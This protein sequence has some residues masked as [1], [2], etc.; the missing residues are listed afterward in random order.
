VNGDGNSRTKLSKDRFD[1]VIFDMDGVITK[2]ATLHATA[3]KELFDAVLET[4]LRPG[5]P[6]R[7]FDIE[8]DYR[9]YVDGKPR[10]DGVIS[11]LASR[12]IGLP[13]GNPS[14]PPTTLTVCGLGNRKNVYFWRLVEK[15]GVEAFA[16]TVDLIHDLKAV[17]IKVGVFSASGNAESILN[18][19]QV[20]AL[21][22]AKVDGTDAEHLELPGKPHPAML[23]EL[24]RRLGS[25]PSRTA[26]VEDAIAGVQAGHAGG[27]ALVIGVN[28]SGIPGRLVES[29][30]NIEVSD[31]KEVGRTSRGY[32]AA[33]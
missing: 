8:E 26:V 5:E 25:V 23:L 1:A 21:F 19:A 10:Y 4:R 32:A 33:N 3:W 29:G 18:A 11:F 28:R 30:A 16:S 2:T 22:D 24:T 20:L 6:W 17:G 9:R 15:R 14:D 7:P 12:G 13:Y 27:F 31:L